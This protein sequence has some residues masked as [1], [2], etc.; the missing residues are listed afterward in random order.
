MT[1][2]N[3]GQQGYTGGGEGLRRSE[4]VLHASTDAT[5]QPAPGLQGQGWLTAALGPQVFCK[6]WMHRK[7]K[8]LVV[9]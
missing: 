8:A 3:T 7:K 2:K 5:P 4:H 9:Y 6:T 1:T